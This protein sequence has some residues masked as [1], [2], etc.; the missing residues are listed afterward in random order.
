MYALYNFSFLLSLLIP[1]AHYSSKSHVRHV[2]AGQ[3]EIQPLSAASQTDP[4]V[5]WFVKTN[6]L[7]R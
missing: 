5:K 4:N 2:R 7:E 6:S 1:D 3:R